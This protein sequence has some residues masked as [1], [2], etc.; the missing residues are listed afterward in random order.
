MILFEFFFPLTHVLTMLRMVVLY[1]SATDFNRWIICL[2]LEPS[3]NFVVLRYVICHHGAMSPSHRQWR[4]SKSRSSYQFVLGHWYEVVENSEDVCCCI[5]L[6]SSTSNFSL[7]VVQFL[8]VIVQN[9][10]EVLGKAKDDDGNRFT[11]FCF[12]VF[13]KGLLGW[14]KSNVNDIKILN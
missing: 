7:R 10:R 5:A 6:L 1:Q 14:Q 8:E 4:T 12:F 11:T 2:V 9:E 13:F 3:A